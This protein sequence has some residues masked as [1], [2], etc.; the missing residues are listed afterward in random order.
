MKHLSTV[1]SVGIVLTAACQSAPR[2][3]VEAERAS[4]R[5]AVDHYHQLAS[6]KESDAL[7]QM[8]DA[9]SVTLPPCDAPITGSDATREF[10]EAFA[11]VPGMAI[12]F[13]TDVIDVSNDGS[14]GYSLADATISMD[15]PDGETFSEVA[16]DVHV[17]R[18]QADGSWKV[19][20][21]VWNSAEPLPCPE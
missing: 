10:A 13:E 15:G 8:Y 12:S 14:M 3:D 5:A 11:D 18:R 17:W 9:A 16:R 21:D 19:V 20:V 6:G 7:A 1:A 2:V 4:L